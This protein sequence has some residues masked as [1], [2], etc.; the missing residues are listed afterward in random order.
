MIAS[1]MWAPI[2]GAK[3]LAEV[4]CW[5]RTYVKD[6]YPR[7]VPG[8]G[9]R[10]RVTLR[11]VA[12]RAGVSTTTASFVL[13]GR[14]DMRISPATE[15][16]VTQAAR[17]LDYRRRLVPKSM[18][19]AGAPAV[20]LISDVVATESF[21][22]EMLRGAIAAA[23]ER[24]HVVLMA[25]S[26]GVDDLETSAIK[27][28][29]SRGVDRFLYA[30]LATVNYP[31]PELLR[32]QRL[33][34]VNNVDPGL[35]AAAVV[36]DDHRGGRAAALALLEAG[37]TTGI[38]VAGRT[39]SESVAGP[40]RLAG[41]RAALR[42]HGR[43]VA[44][45]VSCGWWPDEARTAVAA[46]LETERPTAVIALNDRIAMGVYQAVAAAGLR[47]PADVSVVA[48]DNS[49]LSRWMHPSLT[50]VEL[51]YFDIGRRAVELLLDDG[52]QPRTY[53]MRMGL[54]SR[55][56]VGMPALSAVPAALDIPHR[57]SSEA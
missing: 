14:H 9:K 38:W 48:F 45:H 15:E 25:D 47:I 13:S 7:P 44:G 27:A 4:S 23:T 30:T 51:P 12:D 53:K 32:D 50:S 28:L 31:V 41:I 10:E 54:R 36:P 56:S 33:V 24:G 35:H 6:V 20:G 37:H 1:G 11:D 52:T 26:E 5:L 3:Y 34:L 29:R 39:G 21:A 43:A 40:R 18:L 42:D 8:P 49:D 22:G 57:H 17:M 55:E 46:L 19:P 16:R 2:A